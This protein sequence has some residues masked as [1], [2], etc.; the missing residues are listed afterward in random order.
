MSYFSLNS[1]SLK[2][3]QH[4]EEDEPRISCRSS[5]G[6]INAT[7]ICRPFKTDI[8][9]WKRL[10]GTSAFLDKLSTSLQ[11]T[12]KD[13]IIYESG[14]NDQ[15][16]TWVHM[17]VALELAHWLIPDFQVK[18]TKR[19][20]ELIALGKIELER[21]N[22]NQ[23]VN[24]A[25]NKK[26]LNLEKETARLLNEN[27]NLKEEVSELKVE[28]S[29]VKNERDDEIAERMRISRNHNALCRKRH[30]H[31]YQRQY[32]FYVWKDP[33]PNYLRHKLGYSDRGIDGRLEDERTVLPD[34]KLV[35]LVYTMKAEFLEKAMLNHFNDKR[36]EPNH[37]IISGVSS[38]EIIVATQ[39]TL[40]FFK[41]EYEIEP[42][43]S[44]YNLTPPN[45]QMNDDVKAMITEILEKKI[46]AEM[47]PK[48][49][50]P[51]TWPGCTKSYTKKCHLS[52][53]IK[54]FHTKT[55]QVKCPECEM[56]LSCADSLKSHLL[57]HEEK[58]PVCLVCNK[59]L[60]NQSSLSR[61]MLSVHGD[62]GKIAC[63]Q[64]KKLIS[65]SNL[66][67]H[68][69]RIHEKSVQFPCKKCG[70][71]LAS[72]ANYDYHVEKVCPDSVSVE[73]QVCGNK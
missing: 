36:L 49:R 66:R 27:K 23:A 73:A 31:K 63:P 20:Y 68:I 61:H 56:V 41:L 28:N 35:M 29:Q 62:N 39:K 18:I 47:N 70:K 32:C 15:R 55:S 25:W 16:A 9:Q 59:E 40:D 13:L 1:L 45:E 58:K 37:E 24:N 44:E 52:R 21:E 42:D 3:E 54:D 14:S 4:L 6:F 12:V 7:E 2:D 51:C 72:K 5:D 33:S 11:T 10:K 50:F 19:L 30:Y 8:G 48:Q 43:I 22:D 38:E 53:H 57:T 64:C 69:K 67:L 17:Q 34:F 26:I 71:V 60:S 65:K 46:D